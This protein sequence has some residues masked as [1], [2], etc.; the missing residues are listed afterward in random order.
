VGA[1]TD[2]ATEAIRRASAVLVADYGRGMAAHPVLSVLLDARSGDARSGDAQ[3]SSGPVVW[4]PHQRGPRPPGGIDLATPNLGEARHLLGDPSLAPAS[5]GTASPLVGHALDAAVALGRKLEAAVAVTTGASGAVLA[6]P[7]AEPVVVPVEPGRGDPCGAG[8]RFAATVAVARAQGATR[9][10]AVV[11][12][13]EAARRHVLGLGPLSDDPGP[14]SSTRE[15]V[16]ARIA[17]L[18]TTG[19]R[20]VAAGGC[21]DVLHAGHV[22]MLEAAR[23]MGD[24]LVVCVNGDLSVRRLKGRHRPINEVADRVTV[25]RGLA[26]VDEVVVFDEDTPCDVLRLVRPDLFVKGADYDGRSLPE[27][28]VVAEWGGRLVLLPLVAGRSTTGILDA[29]AAAAS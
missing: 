24:A 27:H 4:D 19:R 7:G 12:G 2:A 28:D 29:A 25:L 21:F 5:G 15:G 11:R 13:V 26:C 14:S 3:S 8:D 23:R 22:Q 9:L 16:L 10:E 1:W 18:R 6:E 20:V 17:S